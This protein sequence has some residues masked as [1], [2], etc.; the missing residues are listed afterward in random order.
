M[1]E[2]EYNRLSA[3][4]IEAKII[5]LQSKIS[6]EQLGRCYDAPIPNLWTFITWM[7]FEAERAEFFKQ[8]DRFKIHI[9]LPENDH[10]PL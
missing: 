8:V 1:T 2:D 6:K 5:G 10:R 9:F 7:E 3:K 4:E